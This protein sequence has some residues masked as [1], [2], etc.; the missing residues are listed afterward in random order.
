MTTQSWERKYMGTQKFH[1][2]QKVLNLSKNLSTCLLLKYA[3][4]FTDRIQYTAHFLDK[5]IGFTS[6][7]ESD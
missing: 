4:S 5:F 6:N 3:L 7:D 1:N 2:S